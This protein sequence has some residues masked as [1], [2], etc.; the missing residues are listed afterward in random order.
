MN[1]TDNQKKLAQFYSNVSVTD[2]VNIHDRVKE[3]KEK[4]TEKYE[5]DIVIKRDSL[6]LEKDSIDENILYIIFDYQAY[7]DFQLEVSLNAKINNSKEFESNFMKQ[8]CFIKQNS[9]K[10]KKLEKYETFMDKSIF[11]NSNFFFQNKDLDANC[12]DLILSF[13]KDNS[14]LSMCFKLSFKRSEKNKNEYYL[15]YLKQML[16]YNN[17]WFMMQD[18]YG[19]STV[20]S[21]YDFLIK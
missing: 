2:N 16:H 4:H 19:L 6:K 1:N 9:D 5:N 18:I 15:K 12:V 20:D 14:K 10:Y 11:V 3:Q 8:Y 17:Q 13:I 7:S 21:G